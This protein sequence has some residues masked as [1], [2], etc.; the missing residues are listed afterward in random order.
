[1]T[2]EV[3]KTKHQTPYAVRCRGDSIGVSCG[4]VYL[5]YEGQHGYLYQMA[6][7]DSGWYCP[8]CGSTASFQDE[9]YEEA[10]EE[11]NGV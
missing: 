7:P 4:L 1:M 11:R 6:K 2:E 5:D 10:M 3:K 8:N 9:V